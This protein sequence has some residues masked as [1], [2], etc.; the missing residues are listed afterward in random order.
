MEYLDALADEQWMAIAG[1]SLG[2]LAVVAFGCLRVAVSHHAAA[3]LLYRRAAARER[4]AAAFLRAYPDTL[5]DVIG[6]LMVLEARE[7]ERQEQT[8]TAWERMGITARNVG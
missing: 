7:R 3:V 4:A 5:R 8:Q 1:L 2:F 6:R